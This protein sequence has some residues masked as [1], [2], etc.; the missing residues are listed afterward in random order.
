MY[1][2]TEVN[3]LLAYIHDLEQSRGNNPDTKTLHNGGEPEVWD[4]ESKRII[5]KVHS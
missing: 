1:S 4:S 5:R 3:G 2:E